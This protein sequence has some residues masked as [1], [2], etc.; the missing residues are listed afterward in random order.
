MDIVDYLKNEIWFRVKPSEVHGVGLFAIR[1]IP[2]DTDIFLEY[3]RYHSDCEELVNVK[4]D[5]N[6]LD[7]INKNIKKLLDDYFIVEKN[8]DGLYYDVSITNTWKAFHYYFMNHSDNPNVDGW[9][10]IT[11]KD[12]K[13]GEELFEDYNSLKNKGEK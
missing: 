9:T 2:K 12:I 13:D 3:E 8:A 5:S 4:G 6:L 10:G 1:D 11:L 7:G